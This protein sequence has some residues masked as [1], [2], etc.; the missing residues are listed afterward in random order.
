MRVLGFPPEQS[1]EFITKSKL[2]W[3]TTQKS[4][5]VQYPSLFFATSFTFSFTSHYFS[6][7]VNRNNSTFVEENVGLELYSAELYHEMQNSR[8]H[9]YYMTI[10]KLRVQYQTETKVFFS[11]S[12]SFFFHFFF[13]FLSN[14]F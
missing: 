9:V 4:L 14:I 13:L 2:V 11:F 10:D 6:L 12:S 1:R 3:R 5:E 7:M 8:S